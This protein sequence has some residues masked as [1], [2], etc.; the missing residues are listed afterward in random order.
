MVRPFAI[1]SRSVVLTHNTGMYAGDSHVD[2]SKLFICGRHALSD[3]REGLKTPCVCGMASNP[4]TM[5]S[6]IQVDMDTENCIVLT[7]LF[8]LRGGMSFDSHSAVVAV[9][10]GRRRG[11]VP[12]SLLVTIF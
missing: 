3:L 9:T 8:Y 10:K 7:V 4:W 11:L 5:D 2:D 1:D 6:T 12:V